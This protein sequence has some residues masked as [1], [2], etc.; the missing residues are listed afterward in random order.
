M[1][2]TGQK[3]EEISDLRMKQMRQHRSQALLKRRNSEETHDQVLPGQ[4]PRRS[5]R[6]A[7]QGRKSEEA[8]DQAMPKVWSGP[9]SVDTAVQPSARTSAESPPSPPRSRTRPSAS[10]TPAVS[11]MC[12]SPVTPPRGAKS[13]TFSPQR[14]EPLFQFQQQPQESEE[15]WIQA[16]I[17]PFPSD[18]VCGSPVLMS[19]TKSLALLKRHRS[20]EVEVLS[21]VKEYIELSPVKV[22]NEPKL[23]SGPS[24]QVSSPAAEQKEAGLSSGPSG[25]PP[26]PVAEQIDHGLVSE[27]PPLP[28]AALPSSCRQ[29]TS[30]RPRTKSAKLLRLEFENFGPFKKESVSLEGGSVA[31]VVGPNSSGKSILAHAIRFVCLCGEP[32]TRGIHNL[33][34]LSNPPCESGLV[35]AHFVSVDGREHLLRREA[36]SDVS[37]E[38][39]FWVA[40]PAK[41]A[42]FKEVTAEQYQ[43]YLTRDLRWEGEAVV[44]SQFGLLEACGAAKI[45]ETLPAVLGSIG[46]GAGP[47]TGPL[48]RLLRRRPGRPALSGSSGGAIS[49]APARAEAWLARRVDEI[50]RELSRQPLDEGMEEWGEGGQA[51]LRRGAGGGFSI[52]VS[53][54]RGGASVGCGTPLESLDDGAQD[55]CALALILALPGLR[56]NLSDAPPSFVLLD[57]PD[58]RL[59]QRHAKAL[60]RFLEGPLGPRQSVL[61]SLNNHSGFDGNSAVHQM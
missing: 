47:G 7:L 14:H 42:S 23:C 36:C 30:G 20:Q 16:L 26:P 37:V 46:G 12:G 57:E 35:T 2:L 29:A 52:T 32:A 55:L 22:S 10:P 21:P 3:P 53:Q 13:S 5:Q 1:V 56:A 15:T 18:V 58:S 31:C 38:G 4:G 28:P 24:G 60:L 6:Q 8:H 45:L 51:L 54:R 25:L 9:G 19:P 27:V 59:D 43:T 49:S 44:L 17:P 34:R 40:V 50:Y 61:L 41:D 11:M 33:V 39:R 48:Q